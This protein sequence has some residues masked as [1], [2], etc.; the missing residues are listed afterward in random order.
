MASTD[1]IAD[2]LTC[3]RNACRAKMRRVDVP[4]SRMKAALADLFVREHFIS[5]FKVVGDGK[6]PVLRLYLKYDKEDK[7]VIRGLRR[8][9]TPGRRVYV[10]KDR[11]PRVMGGMGTSVVST[12]GGLLS[13]KE[14]RGKGVGGELICYIW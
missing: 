7:S 13:D 8:V 3:V 4:A 6:K 5:Q 10:D 11:L 1:P 2:F 12:S 14:A 9:S